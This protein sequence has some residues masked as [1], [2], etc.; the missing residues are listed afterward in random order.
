MEEKNLVYD[1]FVKSGLE[2]QA[3]ILST[4]GHASIGRYI[5]IVDSILE[6]DKLMPNRQDNP[7]RTKFFSESVNN[8]F[9]YLSGPDCL[10]DLPDDSKYNN[11][12]SRIR[13]ILCGAE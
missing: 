6:L 8:I 1:A 13:L 7:E 3:R 5:A 11:L 2:K 4:N 10:K 12:R 9:D